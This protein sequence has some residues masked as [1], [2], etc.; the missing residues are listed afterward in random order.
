MKTMSMNIITEVGIVNKN[1]V[2][3]LSVNSTPDSK[4]HSKRQYT[5][6]MRVYGWIRITEKD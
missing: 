4:A 2:L 1:A 6:M 3:I 5:T